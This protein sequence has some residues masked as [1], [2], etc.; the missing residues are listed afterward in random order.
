MKIL[1]V[2][3]C[4]DNPLN[5]SYAMSE[6]SHIASL[7]THYSDY[8]YPI[9]INPICTYG[10]DDEIMV[11]GICFCCDG[12][13]MLPLHN[14]CNS[15]TMPC[16]DNDCTSNDSIPCVHH[17]HTI[18]DNALDVSH[19]AFHNSSI[20]YAIHNNKPIMMDDMFLYHASHLFEHW[21]FCANQH[22]HVRIIM[23][24]VYIYHMHTIFP[25]S[26][27]CVGTHETCLLLNPMS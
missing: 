19:D 25:L 5:L 17:L 8:A 24:D 6:I 11:I 1:L 13:A 26:L 23:D 2:T 27:F 9:K 3:S 4:F 7:Q 12:I 18:H 14:L 16:H 22:K 21:I 15:S 10:I 20:H